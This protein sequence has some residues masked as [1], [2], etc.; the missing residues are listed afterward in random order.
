MANHSLPNSPSRSIQNNESFTPAQLR[1]IAGRGDVRG[2]VEATPEERARAELAPS[3]LSSIVIAALVGFGLLA[4]EGARISLVFAALESF[5]GDGSGFVPFAP[6]LTLGLAALDAGLLIWL[7]T[8]AAAADNRSVATWAAIG[9][10]LV[11]TTANSVLAMYALAGFMEVGPEPLQAGVV[12]VAPAAG[13]IVLLVTRLFLVGA[14]AF[15]SRGVI[16]A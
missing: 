9:A 8:P 16:R 7:F 2:R 4:I 13:A 1:P 5:F 12:D 6:V 14:L 10:W 11:V 3:R 15:D